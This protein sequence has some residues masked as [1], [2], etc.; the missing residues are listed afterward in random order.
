MVDHQ[1]ATPMSNNIVKHTLLVL[2]AIM[3][4]RMHQHM[5][6]LNYVS[7]YVRTY[8]RT[9]ICMH[10][11]GRI[12]THLMLCARFQRWMTSLT[13]YCTCWVTRRTWSTELL[14]WLTVVSQLVEWSGRH[15]Q[16]NYSD[17][18][19]WFHSLLSDQAD[20]IN[21]TTL[22][23]DGG[24]TACWVIRIQDSGFRNSLFSPLAT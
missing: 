1:L 21:G 15:D 8:V 22:M 18:W 10:V 2:H 3:Y 16:R 17:G 23:V 14:W 6:T 20:M 12:P 4:A 19:R 11:Y 24:F 9:Y 7:H 5:Y 13:Q